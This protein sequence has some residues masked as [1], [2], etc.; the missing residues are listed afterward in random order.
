MSSNHSFIQRTGFICWPYNVCL[1]LVI[2]PPAEMK[3]LLP[4][5]QSKALSGRG[6][7]HECI[8]IMPFQLS[9]EVRLLCGLGP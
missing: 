3:D 7:P 2:F 4:L 1:T 5:C 8:D 9:F 6:C